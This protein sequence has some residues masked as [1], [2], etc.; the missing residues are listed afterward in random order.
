MPILEN[1]LN[2][3]NED[4]YLTD[5]Y[6]PPL[7][8]RVQHLT[9]QTCP[10]SHPPHPPGLNHTH[11][12]HLAWITPTTPTCCGSHPPH[13]PGLNHF[14]HTHLLWIT[15]T[16]PTWPGSHPPHP[17][18]VDHTHPTHLAWITPTTPTCS[19]HTHPT[20]L[21]RELYHPV[22]WCVCAVLLNW[23]E[24]LLSSERGSSLLA[25]LFLVQRRHQYT[26][27]NEHHL[28]VLTVAQLNTQVNLQH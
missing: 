22:N 20:H 3:S 25:L 13:P 17:P 8:C 19:H 6:S 7:P 21:S 28:T 4:L 16:P 11:H 15:P 1:L 9:T 23:K 27:P 10:G 26:I 5:A 12:T 2:V 14:H 24:I 18:V